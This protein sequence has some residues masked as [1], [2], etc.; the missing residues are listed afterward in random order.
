MP[1]DVPAL[2]GKISSLEKQIST[3][4][5][6]KHSEALIKIVHGPGFT[7]P[8]EIEFVDAHLDILHSQANNLHSAYDALVKIA[9]R[10]GS[11]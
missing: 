7:T 9:G 5:D 6:A 10:I 8:R 1:H 4:H 3:L 2:E 11:K